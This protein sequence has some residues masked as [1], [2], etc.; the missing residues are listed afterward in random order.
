MLNQG[1]N[2]KRLI[3]YRMSHEAVPD[4]GGLAD[5]I[6]FLS[7]KERIIAG[8]KAATEWVQAAIQLVMAAAEPN[9]WK[10]ADDEAIT[11]EVLRQIDER[12]KA[13]K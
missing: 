10:D 3:I 12:L 8:A 9:P 11:G 2:V 7:S 13:R 6:A 1:P 4:G 5:G